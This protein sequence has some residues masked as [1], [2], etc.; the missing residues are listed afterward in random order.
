[1]KI[2]TLEN[3]PGKSIGATFVAKTFIYTGEE[4]ARAAAGA[5]PGQSPR[6]EGRGQRED[7]Q[8]AGPKAEVPNESALLAFGAPRLRRR[9]TVRPGPGPDPARCRPT[10]ARRDRAGAGSPARASIEQDES[11]HGRPFLRLRSGGPARPL[12]LA[13]RARAAARRPPAAS[14]ASPASR[15]TTSSSTGSGRPSRATRPRSGDGQQELSDSCRR[16][17]LRRRGH[18][19]GPNEVSFRQNLND[20]QSVKPFREVTKQLN[21]TVKQ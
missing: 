9:R 17:A 11:A 12:P 3:V 5:A 14:R 16:P 4:P 13:P 18:P 21:A 2:N 8:G 20:P 7:A 15:S 10:P 19:G 1:M 6:P